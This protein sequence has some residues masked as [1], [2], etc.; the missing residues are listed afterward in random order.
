VSLVDKYSDIFI[1][2]EALFKNRSKS[3]SKGNNGLF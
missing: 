3:K 1:A 2:K